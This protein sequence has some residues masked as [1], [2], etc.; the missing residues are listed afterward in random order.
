MFSVSEHIIQ[1][2]VKK[3]KTGAA[4]LKDLIREVLHHPN[5]L[6]KDVDTN[7]HKRLLACMEAGDFEVIDLW[8]EGDRNQPVQLY[9]LPGLKVLREL[10]TDEPH[11]DWLGTLHSRSTKMQW[12]SV[13]R[14]VT[15]MA[16]LHSSWHILM[17]VQ[18]R[19]QIPIL[20][21]LYNMQ[22]NMLYNMLYVICIHA[23]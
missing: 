23:F 3:Y 6:V 7:M 20:I 18:E 19:F 9:K 5:F 15:L 14:H 21:V 13:S 22:Y 2:H 10:L 16:L 17:L 1:E 4:E 8:E 12:G 11:R